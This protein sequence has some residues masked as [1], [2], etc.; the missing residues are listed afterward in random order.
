F[1]GGNAD[2][3]KLLRSTD[4]GA[5]FTLQATLATSSSGGL[6]QPSLA[7]GANSVWVCWNNNGTMN[8]RGASVTG[9]GT[10]GAVNAVESVST[11]GSFGNIAIGP[12]GQVMLTYETRTAA[13]GPD[14]ILVNVDADGLG[15]NG[16]GSTITVT[17]TN[18][19]PLDTI[20]AQPFRSI[21]AEAN[22]VYD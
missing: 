8:A 3:I 14:D 15:G 22:V 9:L 5:T 2:A 7:V 11:V 17:S 21:D 6:D 1:T 16:F 4:G 10:V 18:V 19:G 20:P 13:E 12:A